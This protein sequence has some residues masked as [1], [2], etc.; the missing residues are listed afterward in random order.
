MLLRRVRKRAWAGATA[1]RR[2]FQRGKPEALRF[3][4]WL[5]AD[6]CC[7]SPDSSCAREYELIES[8]SAGCPRHH[9]RRHPPD[10]GRR[11]QIAQHRWV[12]LAAAAAAAN[13]APWHC[14]LADARALAA[15]S[16]FLLPMAS[17]WRC[18]L[19]CLAHL[20]CSTAGEAQCGEGSPAIVILTH[21]AATPR[22][23]L[24]IVTKH[25]HL[26]VAP[27]ASIQAARRQES[28]ST[29]RS[30]GETPRAAR[31]S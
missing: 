2:C 19:W 6:S 27:Q 20:M 3:R 15:A 9:T 5:R 14:W 21:G 7:Y 25:L 13:S 30:C 4:F 8:L 18:G 17:A 1:S 24:S 23:R 11:R 22:Y 12:P 28:Q 31:S 10:E 26:P 29:H 16:A